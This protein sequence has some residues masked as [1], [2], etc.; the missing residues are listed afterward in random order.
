M[1]FAWFSL[2]PTNSGYLS[3]VLSLYLPSE[4]I[5]NITGDENGSIPI[6]P[7]FGFLHFLPFLGVFGHFW[8]FLGF[9][10]R[11]GGIGSASDLYDN[12]MD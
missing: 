6:F 3:S 12:W 1:F 4:M 10:W 8:E 5:V 7:V 9:C 2:S 11:L